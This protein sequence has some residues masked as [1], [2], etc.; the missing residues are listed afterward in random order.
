[1][2]LETDGG[3]SRQTVCNLM[4]ERVAIAADADV[5]DHLLEEP[6]ALSEA[7]QRYRLA[8]QL[9]ERTGRSAIQC[10]RALE[11]HGDDLERAAAWLHTQGTPDAISLLRE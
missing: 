2:E 10:R 8:K 7:G 3:S 9:R 6:R 1:M 11:V 4:V 5:P